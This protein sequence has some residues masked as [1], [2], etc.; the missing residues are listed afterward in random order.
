MVN[1]LFVLCFFSSYSQTKHKLYLIPGH[2]SDIR[3]YS[4]IIFPENVDTIHLHWI[5]PDKDE[6]LEDYA[7]R[8]S[9]KIDTSG[10]YSIMGLSL[11]GMIACEM[12]NYLNPEN[13]IIISSAAGRSELPH[14]YRM[15]K[16]FQLYRVFS[17][18]FYKSMTKTAQ[19]VYEPDR[20]KEAETFD[21][22]IR[23]KDPLFIKRAIHMIVN[24]EG[25]YEWNGTVFHI[26]GTK[27][28]TIPIRNICADL[29][30]ERG[31]HMMVLTNPEPVEEM[32]GLIFE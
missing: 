7:K 28:H 23:D 29:I 16:N 20:M 8:F 12:T 4:K 30:I 13:V 1:I 15:M 5:M 24:W 32:L 22:M 9:Q 21:A 10:D 31:S 18:G 26:H 11:G 25:E 17:P 2:G 27:D 14:R 6:S 19:V 3:I